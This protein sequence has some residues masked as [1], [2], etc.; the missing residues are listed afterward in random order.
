MIA[1][2]V[3]SRN[4]ASAKG[5]A[6]LLPPVNSWEHTQAP[7]AAAVGQ[8]TEDKFLCIPASPDEPV[9]TETI[10]IQQKRSS[11]PPPP[12]IEPAASPEQPEWR[13]ASSAPQKKELWVCPACS[14]PQFQEFAEC[15]QCGII[16]EKYLEKRGGSTRFSG[17]HLQT[18]F[19]RD[20]ASDSTPLPSE[21]IPAPGEPNRPRFCTHCGDSL[22][23]SDKFC[24]SCGNRVM[25]QDQ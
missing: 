7:M 23:A 6:D 2:Q 22:Q 13:S 1:A 4:A 11:A 21:A 8:T 10:E 17:T 16:V 3:T 14:M 5:Q 18:D 9:I 15:P 12:P 19:S 24:C 25:Q 20:Q